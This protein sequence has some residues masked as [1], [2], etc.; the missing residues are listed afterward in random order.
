MNRTKPILAA[1]IFIAMALTL[2]CSDDDGSDSDPGGSSS[3]VGDITLDSQAYLCSYGSNCS[4]APPYT[5]SGTIRIVLRE[6]CDNEPC[7]KEEI[8]VGKVEN[9]DIYLQLP[10]S[11]SDKYLSDI[12]E[13]FKDTDDCQTT[14][15]TI[16]FS[17]EDARFI[18]LFEIR[19]YAEDGLTYLLVVGYINSDNSI[20]T[21]MGFV[22]NIYSTK[23]VKVTGEYE[24]KC[25]DY[26]TKE[27]TNI[28]LK[29]GWNKLPQHQEI[30]GYNTF[31][32]T[33]SN[34]SV[35]KEDV[36]WL[37]LPLDHPQ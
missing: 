8:D 2:S 32:N 29:A 10:S 12:D 14:K 13:P 19:L 33:S 23:A 6:Q 16:Q 4:M 37:L 9:G 34:P 28:D 18:N 27:T 35:L 25:G 26:L 36:K 11:I 3:S 20:I 30:S 31:I 22:H 15:N 21:E 5:G 1:A 24:K 17:S 7:A